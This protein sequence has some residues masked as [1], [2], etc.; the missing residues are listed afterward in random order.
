MLRTWLPDDSF[1]KSAT[2]LRD[3]EVH[4]IRQDVLFILNTLAGRND[5]MRHSPHVVMWRGA[6]FSLVAYGV[7]MCREWKTRGQRDKLE[8]QIYAFGEEALRT[9]AMNPKDNGNQPWWLGN[10]GFH[11]SHRSGL[12]SLDSHYYKK[13]WKDVPA[14]LPM[15]TPVPTAPGGGRLK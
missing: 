11:L 3:A 10:E 7:T 2:L 5:H 13:I 12:I 6:E 14:D 15:V 4:R 9:G 1:V 8:D